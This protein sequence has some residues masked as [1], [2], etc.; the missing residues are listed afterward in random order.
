MFNSFSALD[1][2]KVLEHVFSDALVDMF[3]YAGFACLLIA[4]DHFCCASATRDGSLPKRSRKRVRNIVQSSNYASWLINQVLAT[5]DSEKMTLISFLPARSKQCAKCTKIKPLGNGA[6]SPHKAKYSAAGKVKQGKRIRRK[7][8][9]PLI[10]NRFQ[11]TLLFRSLHNHVRSSEWCLGPLKPLSNRDLNA[12]FDLWN[13][14]FDSDGHNFASLYPHTVCF[15]PWLSEKLGEH[16]SQSLRDHG[17]AEAKCL[18]DT[19]RSA[20]SSLS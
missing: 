19:G 10:I 15:Y 6:P 17:L 1:H 7:M 8:F 13:R 16:S 14:G 11:N 12:R 2:N 18:L 9:R 4:K 3:G 5:P 20:E